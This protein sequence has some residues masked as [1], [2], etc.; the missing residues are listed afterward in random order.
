MTRIDFSKIGSR[1]NAPSNSFEE[2]I[3]SLAS[4]T[5]D[6]AHGSFVDNNGSGGDGGVECYWIFNN[7]NE[8]GWQAKYFLN[9]LTDGQWQQITNSVQ[10]ALKKHPNLTKYFVCLPRNLNDSRKD[11]NG[12][13]EI[14]ERDKWYQNVQ[15]WNQLAHANG[16]KVDF[17]LWDES[18]I[19]NQILQSR[20]A[21]ALIQYW[22]GFNT[23][24]LQAMKDKFKQSKSS[25]G[26][27]YS[28]ETNIELPIEKSLNAMV[29]NK[30]W[31]DKTRKILVQFYEQYHRL[32][33]CSTEKVNSEIKL[34]F[35]RLYSSLDCI[36]NIVA[37]FRNNTNCI[38][39]NDDLLKSKIREILETLN[40]LFESE[41]SWNNHSQIIDSIHQQ[42]YEI[43]QARNYFEKCLVML[44]SQTFQA[45]KTRLLL[46]T[47]PAGSGKSHL[48]C[49]F[50][51]NQLKK[52]SPMILLLG[53]NYIGGDPTIFINKSL[54]LQT[55]D[56]EL[57]LFEL[58]GERIHKRVIIII[59]ALNEGNHSAEWKNYLLQLKQI[60][61]TH[62]HIGL[63][64]S[65]RSTYENEIIGTTISKE[66]PTL[67]HPGFSGNRSKAAIKYLEKFD[68]QA[69]NV[70]FMSD[71]MTNPLFLRTVCT[72]MKRDSKHNLSDG[73]LGID[74]LLH[75]YQDSI[76]KTIQQKL[77]LRSQAFVHEVINQFTGLLFPNHLYGISYIKVLEAF[78]KKFPTHGE[79]LLNALIS[80]GL[81]S[82]S[83]SID[84]TVDTN[85]NYSFERFSDMYIS[86]SLIEKY[87]SIDLLKEAL[88]PIN[89][90][91]KFIIKHRLENGIIEILSVLV[92][93][94]FQ[95][96]LANLIDWTQPEFIT[97]SITKQD[98]INTS[99]AHGITLR[100]PKAFSDET[101][102]LF[103]TISNWSAPY[104][105]TRFDSLIRLSL[106]TDHPWNAFFLDKTLQELDTTQLDY[107]W[108]THIAISD[109]EETDED[110]A[111]AIRILLNWASTDSL[112]NLSSKMQRLL[113][114]VLTWLTT[115]TNL[116]T[117]KDAE[118]ALSRLLTFAPDQ[119]PFLIDHFSNVKDQYLV[120][121]LYASIYAS[122]MQQPDNKIVESIT[123]SVPWNHL[124]KEVPD[125]L[126]R[127]SLTGIYEYAKSLG[128]TSLPDQLF[129]IHKHHNLPL[130][131][132]PSKEELDKYAEQ[133]PGIERSAGSEFGDFGKYTMSKISMWSSTRITDST[134]PLTGSQRADIFFSKTTTQIASLY[135]QLKTLDQNG[136]QIELDSSKDYKKKHP[137]SSDIFLFIGFPLNETNQ[138]KIKEIN[139]SL[140]DITAK[141][142]TH[143]DSE[144]Q[145]LA[146]TILDQRNQN[147]VLPFDIDAA[148]RWVVKKAC[149]L[150]WSKKLFDKFE[151]MYCNE[152]RPP[153]H[154]VVERIGKKYE[155]IALNQFI[156]YLSE[157][158]HFI[159]QGYSDV[160]D[161]IFKGIWQLNFRKVDLTF[162]P[163]RSLSSVPNTSPW[164]E[165]QYKSLPS[166]NLSDQKKW[167]NSSKTIPDFK[168]I[169]ESEISDASWLV[170]SDFTTE[171]DSPED[172]D[173]TLSKTDFWYRVNSCLIHTSD[174][175]ALKQSAPHSSLM[176][177][178]LIEPLSNMHQAY[179]SEYP[180]RN[181]Y[182][183][184]SETEST[185]VIQN[186]AIENIPY[187]SPL[188]I[189]E[190]EAPEE[191]SEIQLYQPS[192]KIIQALNLVPDNNGNWSN[193]N[194]MVFT[195]PSVQY[196]CRS[197]ALFL[198]EALMQY[199]HDKRMTLV[200]LIGGEK[201]LI[202]QHFSLQNDLI[203]N[204]FSGF[205]YLDSNGL[206][207]GCQSQHIGE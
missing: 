134:T 99:F 171:S 108:T 56:S 13:R 205:Y 203:V 40:T 25:L 103:N 158:Y 60:I 141:I 122:I 54:Q 176:D 154:H 7:K 23:P 85:I 116:R 145:Q 170:L 76:E 109:L 2:L 191:E 186:K 159:P 39:E 118:Y 149:N 68:I 61:D 93:E 50:A 187:D 113:G 147:T 138:L 3:C 20:N 89:E 180:Y 46:L 106:Q 24:T 182:P 168:K 139:K 181:L 62:S 163:L 21:S 190:W 195:D 156:A 188:R 35:Q 185:S 11:R 18:K 79:D 31:L 183:E 83:P 178:S 63:I 14:S 90:I 87:N 193:S 92:P 4:Y 101:K 137:D 97:R 96:E 133:C 66:F 160:D 17:I 166:Q 6:S 173:S 206:V 127:D 192:R 29:K 78:Q 41:F 198:K 146:K 28:E 112:E 143:I 162:P 71:E 131:S 111:S 53:Q 135:K 104:F 84:G 167:V 65:C 73:Y 136:K 95:I 189:Y 197:R 15:K 151:V 19:R 164:K 161:T 80:E 43:I 142:L 126:L 157:Q 77:H 42:K 9:T 117:R 119:V 75:F 47:G 177:P 144:N 16:I 201:R 52:D 91:G 123:L 107:F 88:L 49:D 48:L 58:L 130:L 72:A 204:E 32:H 69:P 67:V 194:H 10:T 100:S 98:L 128:I 70:P 82:E 115:T 132:F 22:F 125:I 174:L 94:Q 55:D 74:T 45:G 150:G 179:F 81:L 51:Q 129:P 202:K 36:K 165:F 102:K 30:E 200:W 175:S 33:N 207:K 169:I 59:D 1:E 38:Y 140:N 34:L 37:D 153:Y 172:R 57:E 184:L 114:I 64:I 152:Y 196:N 124:I 155:R 86:Y 8:Y 105:D 121:S 5:N 199:L 148:R 27:R 12:K 44:H 26:E 110:P 120:E